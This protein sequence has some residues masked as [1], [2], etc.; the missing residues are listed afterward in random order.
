[1]RVPYGAGAH[2]ATALVHEYG[3]LL[4]PFGA[5]VV[6]VQPAQ[7]EQA[8]PQPHS[9]GT[10]KP[11]PP[12]TPKA[13][14]SPPAPP[15]TSVAKVKNADAVPGAAPAARMTRSQRRRAK[16][17]GGGRNAPSL[18][19]DLAPPK[20]KGE[21]VEADFM[22]DMPDPR[23]VVLQANMRYLLIGFSISHDGA[24]DMSSVVRRL[25]RLRCI[26]DAY[27][28]VGTWKG[29][30]VR[31]QDLEVLKW[32]VVEHAAWAP[33]KR[34]WHL[35]YPAASCN[36][37][38][39][40]SADR[41]GWHEFRSPHIAAMVGGAFGHAFM[42]CPVNLTKYHLDVASFMTGSGRLDVG[43]TLTPTDS[44]VGRRNRYLGDMYGECSVG[45][46]E[47][48]WCMRVDVREAGC[49]L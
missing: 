20:E 14:T 46:C 45:W 34:L 23:L 12:P 10:G 26:D 8:I 47:V 9:A 48:G 25:L 21:G 33:A 16:R 7:A 5:P 27:A 3:D 29:L 4:V 11:T 38:F 44:R 15:T 35:M 6:T 24:R 32:Q 39:R 2:A 42:D 13:V 37:P 43:L 19:H 49:A 17:A 1:V 30:G 22:E 31:K 18:H 40:G 36:P 41:S 28:W